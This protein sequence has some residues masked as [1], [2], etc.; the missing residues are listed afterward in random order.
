[1]EQ[2]LEGVEGDLDLELIRDVL[3]NVRDCEFVCVVYLVQIVEI[4]SV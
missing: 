2:K 4:L 1:M 3:C